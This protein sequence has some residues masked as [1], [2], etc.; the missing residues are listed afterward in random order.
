MDRW[1]K[2]MGY[3]FALRK[4]TYPERVAPGGQLAYQSWWENQGVAPCYRRFPLAL[5]LKGQGRAEVLPA[6]ADIRDWLPGDIVPA[7]CRRGNTIWKSP[8]WTN[9]PRSPRCGLPSPAGA[10]TDGTVWARSA[11]SRVNVRRP[12]PDNNITKPVRRR[13]NPDRNP[14]QNQITIT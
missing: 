4:F 2:R 10:R 11:S 8:F 6:D 14:P 3:R 1:L 9:P 12:R 7:A 5:R 13:D